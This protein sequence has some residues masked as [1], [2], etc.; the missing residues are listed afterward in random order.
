M[1]EGKL[2]REYFD[3]KK[4]REPELTVEQFGEDIG[5]SRSYAYDIFAMEF[6]PQEIKEP[7]E[8]YFGMVFPETKCKEEKQYLINKHE[9][10]TKEFQNQLRFK[11]ESIFS[12]DKT[13]EHLKADK[14]LD[15][16][17]ISQLEMKIEELE[18]K[19]GNQ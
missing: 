4:K 1:N 15:K 17:K 2:V 12:R 19:L 9:I 7:I 6:I 11:D 5:Y 18:K 13:I 3:E 10:E 8:V 16:N 14:E